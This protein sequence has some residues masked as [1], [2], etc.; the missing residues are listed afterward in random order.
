MKKLLIVVIIMFIPLCIFAGGGEF[1]YCGFFDGSLSMDDFFQNEEHEPLSDKLL[2]QDRELFVEVHYYIREKKLID[3]AFVYEKRG[4]EFVCQ[5]IIDSNIIVN[6]SCEEIVSLSE[7]YGSI[8]Y[9]IWMEYPTNP[10]FNRGIGLAAYLNGGI[11]P[12][13]P[14]I[15][16]DWIEDEKQFKR[17]VIDYS[18]L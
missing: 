14:P 5:L 13:D 18:R 7:P 17:F 9:E 8:G 10:G 15:S 2:L 3:K 4:E 11:T 1:N 6:S 16:L 12:A